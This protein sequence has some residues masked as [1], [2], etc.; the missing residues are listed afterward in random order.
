M[1]Q[2]IEEG[3]KKSK[4]GGAQNHVVTVEMIAEVEDQINELEKDRKEAE[5]SWQEKIHNIET[6]LQQRR[7]EEEKK[8]LILKEK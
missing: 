6:E 1:E 7:L 2:K 5:K 8:L 4:K 3:K